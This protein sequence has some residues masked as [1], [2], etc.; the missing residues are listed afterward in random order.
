MLNENHITWWCYALDKSIGASLQVFE[1]NLPE[2]SS[3]CVSLLAYL[4][5]YTVNMCL[6]SGARFNNEKDLNNNQKETTKM[7]YVAK[8]TVLIN[9]AGEIKK[10]QWHFCNGNSKTKQKVVRSPHLHFEH[11]WNTCFTSAVCSSFQ[12]KIA[13]KNHENK[14]QFNNHCVVTDSVIPIWIVNTIY[15]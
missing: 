12:I 15:I 11:H 6:H 1:Y 14:W 8:T 13:K 3:R 5:R 2:K 10:K 4:A 9:R 7:C